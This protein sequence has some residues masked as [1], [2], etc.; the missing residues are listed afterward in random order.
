MS[1]KTKHTVLGAALMA[2]A[3]A[4]GSP[5]G[6]SGQGTDVR[7]PDGQGPR[8]DLGVWAMSFARA[9]YLPAS[10][11]APRMI[12]SFDGEPEIRT[13][14]PGGPAAGRLEPGDRVV[15]IDGLLI[16]SAEGGRRWSGV[17]AGRTQVLV[18]RREGRE[19][20]VRIDGTIVCS[21]MPDPSLLARMFD[22]ARRSFSLT[23][24]QP[25]LDSAGRRLPDRLRG[26]RSRSAAAAEARYPDSLRNGAFTRARR[27]YFVSG[28]GGAPARFR[29]QFGFGLSCVDC[30]FYSDSTGAAVAWRFSTSPVVTLVEDGGPAE[31]AGLR[32]DDV[33]EAVDGRSIVSEEGSRRFSEAQ[34]GRAVRLTVRRAGETLTLEIV[35]QGVPQA[36]PPPDRPK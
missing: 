2:A 36:A 30:T 9:N 28:L 25:P 4:A 18:V 20:E 6:A 33:I 32:L 31:R 10:G 13:L 21:A 1:T 34:P 17:G 26:P 23:W 12:W 11:G 22:S 8:L 35:P 7:C 15:S 14:R 16:T 29:L 5:S 27:D 19:R 3:M 24:A